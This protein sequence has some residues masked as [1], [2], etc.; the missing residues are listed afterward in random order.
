MI[1]LLGHTGYVGGRFHQFLQEQGRPVH[2]LSR[3]EFDY[4]QRSGMR[5]AL[6]TFDP[7]FVINAAGYTGKPNVDAA[8]SD[9][10]NCLLGNAILPGLLREEC[11]ARGIPWGHISSGCIFQG[12]RSDGAGFAE[13]D[14]PNFSFRSPPCSFYSG[15]KA[16]G[17]ECLGYREDPATGKW[18]HESEPTGY[19]WR[20][21]I[22]FDHRDGARNYLSKLLRY[23]RLL[24]AENS[25]SHLDEFVETCWACWEKRVPFGIYNVT[26]P[27]AITTRQVVDWIRDSAVGRE[28]EARGKVF[29]FFSDEDEFMRKAAITPRSNCVMD[30][31]KLER[32]GLAMRPIEAA[33]R[34][35]LERWEPEEGAR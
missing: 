6:E 11:D 25:I 26:N 29:G 27:G 4:T 21:R 3:G 32:V 31:G 18:A 2:G 19:V 9:R 5:A 22:P 23:Q 34:D 1:L 17:E 35:A 16:L 8:E 28:M 20:M 12:R 30:S 14:L 15:T 33:V 7:A 13:D 10:T 24:E